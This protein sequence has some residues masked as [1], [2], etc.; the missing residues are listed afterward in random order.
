M[1]N[2]PLK[3]SPK[4]TNVARSSETRHPR[5]EPAAT[6]RFSQTPSSRS[7]RM[8]SLPRISPRAHHKFTTRTLMAATLALAISNQTIAEISTKTLIQNFQNPPAE[9][10]P[11]VRWWWFGA[12]VEKP[13]IL[14]ELQQMK[15]DG[16]GGAELAFVY[17]QV[18]DSM[19]QRRP[20]RSKTSRSSTPKCSTP[21]TTPRPKAAGSAYASTSPS[22]AAGP[23]AAPPPPSPKPQ[24]AS[25]PQRFPSPPTPSPSLRQP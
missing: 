22:A 20:N 14:H 9:A 21:S 16:I 12:A 8:P 15:A 18:L 25:A 3:H 1:N 10:K 4:R 5:S 24:A 23:T 17:P 19:I 7:I 6:D 11:M 2:S 13:E